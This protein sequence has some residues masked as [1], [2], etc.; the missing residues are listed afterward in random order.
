MPD[1]VVR[2]LGFGSD[3]ISLSRGHSRSDGNWDNSVLVGVSLPLPLFNRNQGSIKEA[4]HLMSKADEERRASDVQVRATLVE[5]YH[6]LSAAS[7]AITALRND[8][9][10]AATQ[11]FASINEAYRQ[12]KFGYLDVLDAQRTLFEARQQH[13]D[14]LGSYHVSVAEIERVLGESLWNANAPASGLEQGK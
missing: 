2:G 5:A 11:T 10:P 3:G 4:E 13:L 1:S 9:L 7:A 6:S 14:A 12:G 8:I